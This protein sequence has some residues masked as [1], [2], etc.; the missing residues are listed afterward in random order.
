MG[1]KQYGDFRTLIDHMADR[2]DDRERAILAARFGLD[3]FDGADKGLTLQGVA[4]KM[5]ICKE[6]VRQIQNRA[7]EKLRLLADELQ[8][9]NVV[10]PT[11]W[12]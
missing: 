8:I 6:R 9:G 12:G 11:A 5:G 2:L 4:K 3:N 1:E 7:I 10:D